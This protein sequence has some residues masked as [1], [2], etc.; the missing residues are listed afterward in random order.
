MARDMTLKGYRELLEC[1]LRQG[2]RSYPMEAH[3]EGKA[4]FEKCLLLR[5]DVDKRPGQSLH[6][7]RLEKEMGIS[8]T[9]YFRSVPAS[10]DPAVIRKISELGHEIGYHY[11]DLALCR[12]NLNEAIR[13]FR[14]NLKRL[15]E[16]VPVRTACMHGS[17]LSS[18]DNRLLYE[19]LDP[20]EEGLIG[21]PYFDIDRGRFLYLTDTGGRWD[22][23]ASGIRD[24]GDGGRYGIRTSQQLMSAL[25]ERR[26][27]GRILLTVHPQR[28]IDA[29][30]P[31][32]REQGGQWI[33]NRIKRLIKRRR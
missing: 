16:L 18:H 32:A 26:L 5:H 7:A 27:P 25:H 33:K 2:F 20:E 15:R 9:Y 28:W 19:K 12:G 14:K 23:E 21:E 30:L 29:P 24:E 6:M 11:E 13:S 4:S 22:D 17:P 10:F 31:W 8:G 1:F 3:F